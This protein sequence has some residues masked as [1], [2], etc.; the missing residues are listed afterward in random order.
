ME[1]WCLPSNPHVSTQ[2][3]HWQHK[4][5]EYLPAL[6]ASSHVS[7]QLN[8][9]QHKQMEVALVASSHVLLPV[10]LGSETGA[11]VF[12]PEGGNGRSCTYCTSWLSGSVW[13]VQ[14]RS[15]GH[16]SGT[17]YERTINV[18]RNT[19]FIMGV[20]C[21]GEGNRM[22]NSIWSYEPTEREG[23]GGKRE[24]WRERR[25]RE[26]THMKSL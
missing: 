3:H 15:C 23:G 26:L 24:K 5:M 18:S 12:L 22:W 6:M 13:T 14:S 11:M 1:A 7:T 8:Q 20:G 10:L 25:A 9:W 4:Q 19:K 2:N 16:H 21:W 17:I